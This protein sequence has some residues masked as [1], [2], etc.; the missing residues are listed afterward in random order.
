MLGNWESGG[1]CWPLSQLSHPSQT[2]LAHA[3]DPEEKDQQT[4]SALGGLACHQG[5]GV[6]HSLATRPHGHENQRLG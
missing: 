6:L 4:S 3:L 2:E 5:P 1:L